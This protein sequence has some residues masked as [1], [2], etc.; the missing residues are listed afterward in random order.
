ML[1]DY[2]TPILGE[3]SAGNDPIGGLRIAPQMRDGDAAD[4]DFQKL[5]CGTQG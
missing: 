2:G 4:A 1:T 5:G 3:V